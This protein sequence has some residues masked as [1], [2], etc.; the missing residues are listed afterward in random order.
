MSS[1]LALILAAEQAHAHG[2]NDA[3]GIG[4]AGADGVTACLQ[5]LY[6]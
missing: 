3:I 2:D 6:R 1:Q 4:G 5:L